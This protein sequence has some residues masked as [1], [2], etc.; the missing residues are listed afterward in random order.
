[1]FKDFYYGTS[2]VLRGVSAFY[3]ER[4]LWRYAVLPMLFVLGFYLLVVVLAVLGAEKTVQ[5]L[6][7]FFRMLPEWLRWTVEIAP[8]FFIFLFL[9]LAGVF[10]VTTCSAVYEIAGALFFD[11]MVEVYEEQKYARTPV[12]RTFS[13][14]AGFLLSSALYSIGTVV[15]FLLLSFLTIFLPVAGQ[16]IILLCMGARFGVSY[17]AAAWF[18]GGY[19]FAE[20]RKIAAANRMIV[21]GYGVMTAVIMLFP[22]LFVFFLPGVILGAVIIRNEKIERVF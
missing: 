15:L 12:R 7:S 14:G 20:C 22:L 9:V 19:S 16:L 17:C 13:S 5:Q 3:S 4:R 6:D 2:C 11:R 21:F 18:S 10:A 1:M 8:G